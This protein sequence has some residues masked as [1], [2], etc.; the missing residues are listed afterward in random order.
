MWF[1][2][3]RETETPDSAW[4]GAVQH[5]LSPR[6]QFNRYSQE[7]EIYY[8]GGVEYLQGSASRKKAPDEATWLPDVLSNDNPH[9]LDGIASDEAG[10]FVKGLI[11]D[12]T[13]FAGIAAHSLSGLI[14]ERYRIREKN[15]AQIDYDIC[16]G[17]TLLYELLPWAQLGGFE[18]QRQ[19]LDIVLF[20]LEREKRMEDVSCWRDVSRVQQ[21]F[22]T[23][24]AD[25]AGAARREGLFRN[26]SYLDR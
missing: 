23:A 25:Y 8:K 22:V 21:E 6:A 17:I 15:L 14:D 11:S 20:G 19:T 12:K 5:P 3:A 7:A 24:L 26:E 16:H 4:G 10:D 9:S 13:K 1:N 2:Y 18:K